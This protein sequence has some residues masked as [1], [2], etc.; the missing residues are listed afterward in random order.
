M[1]QCGT[2]VEF[3]QMLDLFAAAVGREPHQLA[4]FIPVAE[5]IGR[6]AAVERAQP[7][8]VVK[9]VAEEA[10]VRLHPDLLQAFE[11]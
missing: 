8:H 9:L 6:G 3:K 7:R 4:A 11:S 2:V 1:V 10:A 5:D